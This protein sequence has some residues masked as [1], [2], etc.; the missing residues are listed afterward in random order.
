VVAGVS[1]LGARSPLRATGGQAPGEEPGDATLSSALLVRFESGT[2]T[3]V[4]EHAQAFLRSRGVEVELTTFGAAPTTSEGGHVL[5]AFPIVSDDRLPPLVDAWLARATPPRSHAVCVTGDFRIGQERGPVADEAERL[6]QASG[7]RPRVRPLLVDTPVDWR[8]LQGPFEE[9]LAAQFALPAAP[10]VPSAPAPPNPVAPLSALEEPLQGIVDLLGRAPEVELGADGRCV[11]VSFATPGPYPRSLFDGQPRRTASRALAL[12]VE[13][14]ALR[15]LGIPFAGLERMPIRVP[16][17]CSVLDLRGNAFRSYGFLAD[18]PELRALNLA[19]CELDALPGPVSALTR[20]ETL[21]LAKNRIA[22]L[23]GLSTLGLLRRLTLYRNRLAAVPAEIPSLVGL[24]LLNLGANPI[25]RLPPGLARLERLE[26][27][28]LRML[29]LDAFP[30]FLAE[31][32]SLR[33]IDCSKTRF[34]PPTGKAVSHLE[35]PDG[36]P[37]W[38]WDSLDPAPAFDEA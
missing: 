18:V 25:D 11:R 24:E 30:P 8:L 37:A 2:S 9:W 17:R 10:P 20:L 4:A 28:G 1:G 33:V 6:L 19:G 7:S 14:P 22:D 23:R 26:A 21:I 16:Q 12:A 34:P 13:L 27:L 32:P 38:R 3:A 31:L 36:M 35:F 29:P 5:V 15:S